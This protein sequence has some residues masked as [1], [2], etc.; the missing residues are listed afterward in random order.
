MNKYFFLLLLLNPFAA[1]ASVKC[2]DIFFD[3]NKERTLLEIYTNENYFTSF[4]FA[5]I[6]R[7]QGLL[8]A[9]PEPG[10]IKSFAEFENFPRYSSMKTG[11]R[12][13][14]ALYELFVEGQLAS[15]L[16]QY[17]F[18]LPFLNALIAYESAA[19]IPIED[20]VGLNFLL[21]L[22]TKIEKFEENS[23]ER[24]ILSNA[25]AVSLEGL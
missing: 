19:R 13:L 1:T 8:D 24:S 6:V 20:Q 5:G 25:M 4:V 16:Y 11:R 10:S 14:E 21:K 18:N 7:L 12:D 15:I 2:A 23:P 9:M 3:S 22:K 17:K